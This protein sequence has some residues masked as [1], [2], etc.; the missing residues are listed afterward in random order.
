M[1]QA[2][3]QK[4]EA[5]RDSLRGELADAVE[6]S[7]RIPG[8]PAVGIEQGL[9]WIQSSVFEGFYVAFRVDK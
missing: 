9:R 8:W 4:W 5:L 1:N 3:Q 7:V 6:V 2:V